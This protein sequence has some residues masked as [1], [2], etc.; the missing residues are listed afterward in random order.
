MRHLLSRTK[1]TVEELQSEN[2]SLH[3]QLKEP[4]SSTPFRP[5]APSLREELAENGICAGL[6]PVG[7]INVSSDHIGDS[8]LVEDKEEEEKEEEE[9]EVK[10]QFSSLSAKLTESVSEQMNEIGNINL[11]LF[12][13]SSF[14]LLFFPP[15]HVSESEVCPEGYSNEAATIRLD[16]HS[17]H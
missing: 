4:I 2:S 12:C 17:P 7:F 5:Q 9:E 11:L 6:S 8:L 16:R 13:S 14:S 3:T 15:P 10:D 1:E